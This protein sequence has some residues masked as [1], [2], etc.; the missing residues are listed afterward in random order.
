MYRQLP[1]NGAK[2]KFV[3]D[4]ID[5]KK[6][7]KPNLGFVMSHTSSSSSSTATSVAVTEGE[8]T[9]PAKFVLVFCFMFIC[10]LPG[11]RS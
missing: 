2:N 3:K 1:N 10:M 8:F 7:G 9:R 11:I 6:D 5:T 4:F